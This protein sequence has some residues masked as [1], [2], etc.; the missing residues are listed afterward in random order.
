MVIKCLMLI[1][2]VEE[3]S[4][5]IPVKLLACQHGEFQV[6]ISAELE[7]RRKIAQRTL[8]SLIS[9]VRL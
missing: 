8:D 6:T 5:S 2:D 3:S 4:L 1:Y 9:R 7:I